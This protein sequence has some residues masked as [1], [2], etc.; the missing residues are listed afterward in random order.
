MEKNKLER[1]KFFYR[2]MKIVIDDFN[3][4][5]INYNDLNRYIT[6]NFKF[7]LKYVFNYTDVNDIF[8]YKFLVNN[9]CKE[10][11]DNIN[12]NFKEFFNDEF[13]NDNFDEKLIFIS[14]CYFSFIINNF[15]KITKSSDINFE[16]LKY[17]FSYKFND[18]TDIYNIS[19]FVKKIF[20]NYLQNETSEI[21]K[22]FV[23]CL[24]EDYSHG[25]NAI[26]D[27]FDFIID[28]FSE[29]FNK[30]VKLLVIKYYY[31]CLSMIFGESTINTYIYCGSEMIKKYY[32][33]YDDGNEICNFM[34][35]RMI[36][37]IKRFYR[38]KEEKEFYKEKLI[39]C[40]DKYIELLLSI[41]KNEKFKT[42]LSLEEII[43]DENDKFLKSV[44]VLLIDNLKN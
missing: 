44:L 42:T 2:E 24:D 40:I 36:Y 18:P 13:F 1:I 34:I 41:L 39:K 38:K 30:E 22:N 6:K 17:L 11:Y 15:N 33:K 27:R 19:Y 14:E 20:N 37:N 3:E 43:I 10:I 29:N 35:K 32:L 16:I 21:I 5:K 23:K 26:C 9:K 4:N 25:F 31:I 28:N 8:I 12:I 7:I